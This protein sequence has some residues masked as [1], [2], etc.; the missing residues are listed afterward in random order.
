MFDFSGFVREKLWGNT[1]RL[2]QLNPEDLHI[3]RV[4]C[5]MQSSIH[6]H[7]NTYNFIYVNSGSL[8]IQFP[9]DDL[10]DVELPEKYGIEIFPNVVHRF[11]C[12]D[13]ATILES[14]NI[15]QFDLSYLDIERFPQ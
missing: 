14:Y 11:V 7:H 8:L 3:A 6:K 10:E 12:Q 13:E 5:G 15:T 9:E 4:F 2:E 1:L